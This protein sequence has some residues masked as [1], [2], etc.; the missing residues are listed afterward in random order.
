MPNTTLPQQ[1][2]KKSGDFAGIAAI[3]RLVRLSSR[4]SWPVIL[5]FLLVAIVSVGYFTRHFV[6]TTDSNKLLSSSLPWR[7]QEVMLYLAFPQ[8]IDP[9]IALINAHPP[10]TTVKS[11]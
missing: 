1:S 2:M 5:G 11:P 8:R 4:Y 10:E 9:I 3:T 7:Q 6:I